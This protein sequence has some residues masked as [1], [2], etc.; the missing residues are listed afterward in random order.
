[1]AWNSFV[2][3]NLLPRKE[4]ADMGW[5]SEAQRGGNQPSLPGVGPQSL[6]LGK[7]DTGHVTEY[8]PQ[9]L[10]VRLH[11]SRVSLC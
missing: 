10:S 8:H 2:V 4:L 11:N 7:G 6:R 9:L 3:T 5:S 1:M